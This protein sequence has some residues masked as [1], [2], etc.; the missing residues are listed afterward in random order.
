M[1]SKIWILPVAGSSILFMQ[2]DY[3]FSF[4]L[5]YFYPSVVTF[6]DA[7]SQEPSYRAV[8]T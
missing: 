5:L 6:I 4:T 3:G 8:G 2:S 1:Q 7:L